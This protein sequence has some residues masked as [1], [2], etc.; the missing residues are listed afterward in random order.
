MK[1]LI[2]YTGKAVLE[3]GYVYAPYIPLL[4]TPT[5]IVPVQA[6]FIP[7]VVRIKTYWD[8]DEQKDDDLETDIV[9]AIRFKYG[10]RLRKLEWI[11]EEDEAGKRKIFLAS[12]P[13]ITDTGMSPR[14]KVMS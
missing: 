5:M 8:E 1:R 2:G 11:V 14:K 3:G 7:P 10:R 9:H 12:Q 4:A 6:P 13:S